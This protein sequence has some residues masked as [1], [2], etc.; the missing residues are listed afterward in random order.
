M[1]DWATCLIMVFVSAGMEYEMVVI[2]TGRHVNPQPHLCV[3]VCVRVALYRNL[4]SSVKRTSVYRCAVTLCRKD[5]RKFPSCCCYT[6]P[7]N[8]QVFQVC[9]LQ[10][11]VWCSIDTAYRGFWDV[12][13]LA[14][15]VGVFL[16]NGSGFDWSVSVTVNMQPIVTASHCQFPVNCQC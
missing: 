13:F 1:A 5:F 2:W 12:P 10:L 14:I 11:C 9:F 3:C 7:P 16:V 6:L 4:Q 15:S 8:R